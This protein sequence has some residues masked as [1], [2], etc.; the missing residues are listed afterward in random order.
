MPCLPEDII[1]GSV[2]SDPEM[3]DYDH[4]V[5]SLQKDMRE[6][7]VITQSTATKQLQCHTELYNRR[8]HGV[9][10]EVNDMVLLANKGESGKRK[11]ADCWDS[12]VYCM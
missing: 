11:L 8:V 10:V 6:A 12:T 7:M 5:E 9:P 4:Y 2:L 3:V 1:F